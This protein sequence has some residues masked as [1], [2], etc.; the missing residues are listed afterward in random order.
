[1]FKELNRTEL[2]EI[3]RELHEVNSYREAPKDEIMEALSPVGEVPLC[4]L[5]EHREAMQEHIRKNFRRLRTQ[6][7]GCNGKCVTFGCPNL[8]VVRCWE[9]F[10]DDMI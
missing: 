2:Q 10:K 5:T 7:P 6:L 3:L 8:I 1:M 9:A 4:P